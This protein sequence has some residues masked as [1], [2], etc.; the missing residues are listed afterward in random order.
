MKKIP[1]CCA[2]C[3]CVCVSRSLPTLVEQDPRT[4]P[5]ALLK[6]LDSAE[7]AKKQLSPVGVT[8]APMNIECLWEDVSNRGT[9]L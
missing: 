7:R 5:K 8:D 4:K 3:V 2:L 9:V 1:C 6:L